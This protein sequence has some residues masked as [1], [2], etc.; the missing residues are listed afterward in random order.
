MHAL[1]AFLEQP[2]DDLGDAARYAIRN[3]TYGVKSALC[4]L[5]ACLSWYIGVLDALTSKLDMWYA[6]HA[7]DAQ[8]T[9]LK[10]RIE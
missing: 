5:H 9:V 1:N 2:A 3:S 7:V 4:R 8:G 6:F 10:S